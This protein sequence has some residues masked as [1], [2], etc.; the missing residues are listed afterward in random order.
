VL[1]EGKA[2]GS[3]FKGNSFGLFGDRMSVDVL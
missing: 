3:R 1:A 2:V